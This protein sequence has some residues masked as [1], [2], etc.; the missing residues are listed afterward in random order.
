MYDI[1]EHKHRFATWAAARAASSKG[2]RFSVRQARDLIDEVRYQQ[3]KLRDMLANADTLPS[4]EKFDQAHAEWRGQVRQ[5][6]NGH[7]IEMTH[8]V[9]AKLLNVYLKA[10]FVCGGEHDHPR[11]K[12]I[13]PP[14]DRLL[15]NG[16]ATSPES[17]KDWRRFHPWTGLDSQRYEE[18]IGCIR[19]AL[20]EGQALWRIE[21]HWRGYQ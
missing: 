1:C 15:L 6:A 4:P 19:D 21:E 8:G 7:G 18:L 16:L 2:C 12:V 11:V 17:K 10:A 13:H 5:A 20:P 3:L 9:A 14:I